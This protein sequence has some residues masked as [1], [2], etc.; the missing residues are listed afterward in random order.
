MKV[1]GNLLTGVLDANGDVF[2]TDCNFVTNGII[3]FK[4]E[5]NEVI[6]E[7][8]SIEEVEGENVKFDITAKLTDHGISVIDKIQKGVPEHCLTLGAGFLVKKR[9]G[10]L[11]KDFKITEVSIIKG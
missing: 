3:L 6:G 7:V 8:I 4:S 11:I 5:F 2:S 9:D 1:K 10:H